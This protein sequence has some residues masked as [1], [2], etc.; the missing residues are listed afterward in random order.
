L[1]N[2][3]TSLT[4]VPQ[5]FGFLLSRLAAPGALVRAAYAKLEPQ[6]RRALFAHRYEELYPDLESVFLLRIGL[7]AAA[8]WLDRAREGEQA[9]AARSLFFWIY[10]R[11][12]GLWLTGVLDTGD[13][14]QQL[15]IACFAYMPFLF[16]DSLGEAL[17]QAIPPLASDARMLADA[18]ANLRRNG[19][20]AAKLRELV[21]AAG[22]DLDAALRDAHQW[23]T[24]SKR[25]EEF[26]EPLQ[27]LAGELGIRADALEKG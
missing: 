24:L 3:G 26:P 1:I 17:E 14:K 16:G 2:H 20:D 12:R 4:D 15:V 10:E 19:I 25:E 5:R 7:S 6:R 18:C 23:S 22:A 27:K 13:S 11:A 21:A 8:N 9:D